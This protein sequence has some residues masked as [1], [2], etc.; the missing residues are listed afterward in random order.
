MSFDGRSLRYPLEALHKREGWRLDALRAELADATRRHEAR[1]DECRRLEDE[2]RAVALSVL[3]TVTSAID[4]ARA[5]S[6][7]IYL[8]DLRSRLERA[9]EALNTL[10]QEQERLRADSRQ[11]Q[12]RLEA[13]AR[14]REAHFREQAALAAAQQAAQADDDWLRRRG[15]TPDDARAD[16]TGEAR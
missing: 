16:A 15:A 2:H 9:V 10:G 7:L 6:R 5:R 14:H 1:S 3:P 12:A 11:Q 4:P 8:S 13:I